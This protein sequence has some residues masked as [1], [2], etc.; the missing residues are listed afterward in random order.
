MEENFENNIKQ[1]NKQENIE[2]LEEKAVSFEEGVEQA[3]LKILNL[4]ENSTEN[5]YIKIKGSGTEVGKTFLLGRLETKLKEKNI[6]T[7]HTDVNTKYLE[8]K[9]VIFTV[10]EFENFRNEDLLIGIYK[11]DKKFALDKSDFYLKDPDILI[12][13][14]EA[15]N[16]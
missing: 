11:P 6:P 1:N 15:K 12:R 3:V 2:K 5:I 7:K 8:E 10:D 14:D 16:R 4:Y 9:N 13:N